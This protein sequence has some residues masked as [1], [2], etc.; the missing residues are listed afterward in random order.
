MDSFT[1]E[2]E[3]RIFATTEARII[4]APDE[5]PREMA[6]S[7]PTDKVNDS[8]M[9]IAGRFVQAGVPNKNGHFWEI[10]DLEFGN[11]SI[12]HTPMNMLHQWS[13]PV[14]TFVDSQIV[15]RA[16]ASEG[17]IAEIQALGVVWASNF[18][19]AASTLKSHHEEGNLWFSMECIAEKKQC[20]NC[21]LSFDWKTPNELACAHLQE[22]RLAPRR[23]INPTFVGGA[24]IFPPES[25]AWPDA[26][27]MEVAKNQTIEYADSVG[28]DFGTH[29]WNTDE[30]E[31]IMDL[32]T[33]LH[34][35][36]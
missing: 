22:S 25:P 31:T 2:H 13:R 14:G 3:G 6:M 9:W 18:A 26:D 10:E 19:Q 16:S 27:I 12:R 4:S 17:E 33:D 8:Y 20:M 32:V 15:R 7:L 30:W 34:S 11:K 29:E 5:L 24:L 36:M 35:H 28:T 1:F 21:G 23:L